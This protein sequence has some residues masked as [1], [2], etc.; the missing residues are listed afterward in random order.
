MLERPGDLIPVLPNAISIPWTRRRSQILN[1]LHRGPVTFET[2]VYD[3][4]VGDIS[5]LA[6]YFNPDRIS[7][8][9]LNLRFG[10]Y[11]TSGTEKHASPRKI[12]AGGE[13]IVMPRLLLYP[14]HNLNSSQVIEL[15]LS[16][17]VSYYLSVS[18]KSSEDPELGAEPGLQMRQQLRIRPERPHHPGP[19]VAAR[20]AA[21]RRGEQRERGHHHA[22]A[23]LHQ[24][25][26][27][28]HALRLH[29]HSSGLAVDR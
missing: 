6:T 5:A 18:D 19:R 16:V 28:H 12:G 2:L 15:S 24:A 20:Q 8:R 4:N 21:Q 22:A 25:C 1:F 9:E 26:G 27:A 10:H 3:T 11:P 7:E 14:D 17:Y 29:H 13:S 23:R